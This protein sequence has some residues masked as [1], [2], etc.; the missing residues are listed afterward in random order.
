MY[1]PVKLA[2]DWMMIPTIMPK[3]PSALAKISTTNTLTKSEP[4]AASAIA[5][6]APMI[7]THALCTS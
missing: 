5:Q 4:F 1:Y 6:L 7:P 2:L 3:I